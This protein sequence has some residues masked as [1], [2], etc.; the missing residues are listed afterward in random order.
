[1]D[2]ISWGLKSN[3]RR[4]RGSDAVAEVMLD[5]EEGDGGRGDGGGDLWGMRFDAGGESRRGR[6]E[7]ERDGGGEGESGEDCDQKERINLQE[8]A[9]AEA[10]A[11][12]A[13]SG[14]CEEDQGQEE[15]ADILQEV[16]K[17]EGAL[18]ERR[19]EEAC[20]A[21]FHEEVE[22]DRDKEG[23]GCEEEQGVPSVGGE[24]GVEGKSCG[25]A[26]RFEI[27]I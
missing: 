16:I 2:W 23:V 25:G 7:L 19:D 26:F 9:L 24:K 22:G 5:G 18:R 14:V 3:C 11:G 6:G 20:L 1:M 8:A 27:E 10:V 15:A 17:G 4:E 13:E 12:D 21:E